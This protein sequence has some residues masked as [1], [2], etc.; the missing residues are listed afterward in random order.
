MATA[1]VSVEPCPA[2]MRADALRW[3][4]DALPIDQQRIFVQ[5]VEGVDQ[6]SAGVWRGLFI[7]KGAKCELHG[8]LWVQPLAGNTAYVWAAPGDASS[9][10]L[11]RTGAE[12]AGSNGFPI[13]H[14]VV[15]A[16]DGYLSELLTR[17]GFP[18]FAELR[19]LFAEARVSQPISGDEPTSAE[20]RG[21][22]YVPY[23][24]E[25]SSRLGRLIEQ[26]YVDSRD[27]P[28]LDG[29][30][31][32][33]DVLA[34]YRAQGRYSPDEWYFI[35]ETKSDQDIGV[36][37]LAEHPEA[38]NWELVYMGL[39]PA[40]R[41]RGKGCELVE[42]AL[43]RVA[44]RGGERLVVAVDAANHPALATYFR[45]GFVEWDRRIVYARLQARV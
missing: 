44:R 13:A 1:F 5:A 18:M 43:D 31:A 45:C 26:T 32:M 4:H 12:F 40:M 35:H 3:L 17:A 36:L 23:A 2:E 25:Q 16:D 34:G 19:Y 20:F 27:C 30:R 28:G 29:V 15:G 22:R 41:G 38:C 6:E 42:F 14:M 39:T 7:S 10:E 9:L 37:V 11:L 21:F 33:G 8:A 24:G